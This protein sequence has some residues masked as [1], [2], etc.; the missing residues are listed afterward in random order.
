ME[1]LIEQEKFEIEVLEQMSNGRFL[2]PQV[3]VGGT[4]LRLCHGLDRFS[5]DLDFWLIQDIDSKK[6][7]KDLQEYFAMNYAV[8]DAAIKYYTIIFEIKSAH[9]R[10]NL[11]IEIRK[12]LQNIRHEKIIAFSK[13]T[14]RQVLVNA[15]PAEDMMRSKIQAFIS[16]KEIRDCYDIE[17]LLRRGVELPADNATLK[18]CLAII[19][20]FRPNDYKTKLN[21]LIESRKRVYYL[22]HNFTYLRMK[23]LEL[24]A[25]RQ[26]SS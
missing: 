17:F 23:L 22:Q 3:F 12:K 25:G 18:R 21:P 19:D 6:Y 9:F 20:A 1:E 4:M 16:Q 8:K 24:V 13:Y 26:G 7:V 5:I 10:R 11:K 15:L 2:S 14:N